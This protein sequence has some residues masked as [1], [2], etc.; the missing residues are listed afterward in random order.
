MARFDKSSPKSP[1]ADAAVAARKRAPKGSSIEDTMFFPRL[2]RHAKW[3]FVFLALVFGVGFV[4]FGVGAG[5]VG[6]G[7]VLRN[8]GGAG[9]QSISSAQKDTEQRPKDP[10]AWRDLATAYQTEGKTTEAIA[11][12]V[13]AAGLAPKNADIQ[14]ELAGLYLQQAS[15]KQTEAQLAQYEA[16]FRAPTLNFAGSLTNPSGSTVLQD[17]IGGAIQTLALKRATDAATAS[18]EAARLAVASYKRVAALSPADPNVQLELA[19]TAEQVGDTATAIVAYKAFLKLAPDDPNAPI[20]KQQLKQ[21]QKS[22]AS[23][24]G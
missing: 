22:S 15:D 14:R 21:L 5:G 6:V 11:A 2:R 17:P 4:I 20:V 8:S 24:S 7:D 12:L 1:R 9:G 10:T 3:M 18:S 16:A 19:S 13:V 23:A